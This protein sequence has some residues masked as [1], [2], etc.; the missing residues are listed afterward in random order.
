[1]SMVFLK[2][3]NMSITA[4][5]LILAVILAR[6]L[7]KKAPKWIAC[8][9]WALVAAR[10]VCPFTL[11][12][13][14]SLIP[15]REPIPANIAQEREPAVDSG[16]AALD[17]AINPVLSESFAP[18]VG[19]SANPLQ[20][21]IPV[22]TI[23]WCAGIVLLLSYAL[24]SFLRLRKTVSACVPAGEGIF[25]CDEVKTPFIL[26]LFRP[27][28]YVP[29]SMTGETLDVVIRHEK[30]HLRR[31]DHLWKPLGYL[32]LTVHWF[33]PLCWIAYLLLCR[34]IE[35]ACDEKVVRELNREET[36]AYSQAI[37][38]CSLPRKR[39]AACPLAFGEVGV[40]E[41]VKGV[42]NYKKPAFWVILIAVVLCVVLAVCFLTNPQ[43]GFTIDRADIEK[44]TYFNLFLGDDVRGELSPEEIDELVERFSAVDGAKRSGRYEG[45]TPGYQVCVFLKDGS[46]VYGNGYNTTG[47]MVEVVMKG[48][49]YAVSDPEFADYLRR[50]CSHRALT[51]YEWAEL[52][53]AAPFRRTYAVR[54][55]L[56]EEKRSGGTSDIPL[57]AYFFSGSS[58]RLMIQEDLHSENWL[59]AGQLT[60]TELTKDT[61]DRYFPPDGKS[62]AADLR[63]NNVKAWQVIVT[64]APGALYYDPVFYYVL[65]QKDGEVCLTRGH[66]DIAEKDDPHSDDTRISCVFLL[67][68]KAIRI[69]EEI[70][71]DALRAKY[72]DYF[73][74]DTFKGLEVYV[75]QLAPDSWSCGVMPGTN[76]NKTLEE[77]MNLKGASIAE[78]RAIL[79]TY[80]ID[81]EDIFIIPWQ[82]PI[83][84][85]LGDYW[86]RQE[87]EDPDETV[88]R[89]QEYV[90]R[91][92]A[93]LLD[94]GQSGE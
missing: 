66:Y 68:E 76:R 20:I 30:A 61:F 10:L 62:A 19:D 31:R 26:G 24:F 83:S 8:L 72:P 4:S 9:L 35:L 59:D 60:E 6:L 39:I 94:D 7:L 48:K 82:N 37:L 38:D 33:N 36:A 43:G 89:R 90:D 5:W 84:S 32:L 16:I 55:I 88:K 53:T 3:V 81:E 27:R 64:D 28:V 14:F 47:G 70:D 11:E 22:L 57:A 78:M 13:A 17:E 2:I 25:A 41:R 86:V 23:V 85:Y 71:M 87:G 63:R 75:W 21:V 51:P 49:R 40:K 92:R 69:G 44:V 1:M 50:A 29:S 93:L 80:E 18:A 12:S 73:D 34:D 74:L 52:Y 58:K 54:E 56:Y 91:I 15:S 67:E 77:L 45:Q 79:S 42:L 46:F 65:L